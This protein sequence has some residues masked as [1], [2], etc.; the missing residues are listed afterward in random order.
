MSHGPAVPREFVF[1]DESVCGG[2][3]P[4]KYEALTALM[5]SSFCV[6]L[7]DAYGELGGAHP[8][9]AAAIGHT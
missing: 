1:V 9:P 7:F 3:T 6:I 2:I 8:S 5:R 4:K